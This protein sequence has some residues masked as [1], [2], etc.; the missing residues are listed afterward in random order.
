MPPTAKLWHTRDRAFAIPT[1]FV[2][3]PGGAE[4][5]CGLRRAFV[6]L[7]AIEPF[8]VDAAQTRAL[9]RSQVEDALRELF[10]AL[11]DESC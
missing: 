3:P 5:R 8:A 2:V 10:G 1:D 9:A 4:V 6:D 11:D 7:D